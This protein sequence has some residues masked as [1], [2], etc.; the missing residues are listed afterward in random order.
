[1]RILHVNSGNLFGGIEVLLVTLARHRALCPE[2]EPEFAVCFPGKVREELAGANVP[3]H[4]LGA[5]RASRPWTVWRVRRALRAL[6][7]ERGYDAVICHGTWAL[8]L[9]C[10]AVRAAGLPLI[11]WFHDP[12]PPRLGLLDRWARW[13]L[14]DLTICNS[15]YT[16]RSLP[17]L[18]PTGR[19]ERV[20]CPVAP[21]QANPAATDRLATRAAFDTPADAV[22]LLQIGRWEPH[23]GHLH[24]IEALGQLQRKPGWVCWQVGGVQRPHEATYLETVRD[25][26]R[27]HGVADRVRFLGYQPDVARVLAAADVYCQ[28]NVR[29]EPFGIA[30]VEALYAGLPVVA[31]YLGGALEIVDDSCGVLVPPDDVAGLAA[32]LGELIDD[33]ERRARLGAAGPARAAALCDPATQ[34]RRLG[35]VLGRLCGG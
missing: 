21:P 35:Q 1:M 22:V 34:L 18:H 10:P 11:L 26:A 20:Y 28:P 30:F 6:L 9:L 33:P 2:M 5:A 32:A 15:D 13:A 25:A 24:H 23:K 29:P 27:H 12:L 16:L 31:T 19:G 17:R 8:A 14:T 3:V 7:R 4:V